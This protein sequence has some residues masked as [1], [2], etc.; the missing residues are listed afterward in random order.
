MT[1]TKQ[2]WGVY[3]G[4]PNCCIR[5]F[6]KLLLADTKWNEISQERKA[7]TTNGFVPCQR[8]AERVLKGEIQIQEL[9]LPS[10]QCSKP[11]I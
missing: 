9:I 6:H 10:R 3:Y 1:S 7:V 4:Y 8:C 5:S 2:S 11:F